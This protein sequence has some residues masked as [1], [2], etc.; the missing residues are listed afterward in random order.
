MGGGKGTEE[1]QQVGAWEEL[2]VSRKS[3]GSQRPE[4]RTPGK[5][6]ASAQGRGSV[7]QSRLAG[8]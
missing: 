4:S 8:L 6:T 3:K 1:Q 7:R 5:S 2:T